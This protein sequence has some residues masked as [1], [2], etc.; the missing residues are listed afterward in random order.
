M[1]LGIAFA[2]QTKFRPE[3]VMYVRD[4]QRALGGFHYSLTNYRLRIDYT[5]HN[6]SS[7][8]CGARVLAG[9]AQGSA[10]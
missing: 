6:I 8:L 7:L 9:A 2:L 1:E 10:Q 5:Q 4:P 3:S